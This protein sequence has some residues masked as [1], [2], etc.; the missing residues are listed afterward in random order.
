MGERAPYLSGRVHLGVVPG[1]LVHEVDTAGR[2]LRLSLL[3]GD[4]N[5]MAVRRVLDEASEN[6]CELFTQLHLEEKHTT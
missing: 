2:V 6:R 3:E 4:M 1:G 5:A